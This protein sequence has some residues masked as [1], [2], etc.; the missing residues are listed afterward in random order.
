MSSSQKEEKSTEKSPMK[1]SQTTDS[2]T[3]VLV[4]YLHLTEKALGIAC[5]MKQLCPCTSCVQ[6]KVTINLI[7]MCKFDRT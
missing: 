3:G 5:G 2:I 6:V 4:I 1:A 7:K